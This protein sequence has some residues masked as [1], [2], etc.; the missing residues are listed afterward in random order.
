MQN[1]GRNWRR[2][3]W[4]LAAMLIAVGSGQSRAHPRQPPFQ[5]AGGTASIGQG[6]A[7]MLEVT[8]DALRFKCP[9]GSIDMPFSAITRMEYRAEVSRRVRKLKAAWK[10]VPSPGGGKE[11]RYF[12]VVYTE[13]ASPQVMVLKVAPLAMRPYLAEIELKSGKRVEVMGYEEY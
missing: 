3:A 11:N 6:C 13:Q 7:G 10:V 2:L 12:T 8:S 9:K 5:Y 1:Q 4:T